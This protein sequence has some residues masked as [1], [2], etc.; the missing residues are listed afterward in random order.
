MANGDKRSVSTDALETLGMIHE[1]EEKR[2]AIHLAVMPVEAGERLNPG[3]HIGIVNGK[4]FVGHPTCIGVVDP[5]LT[6][7][8]GRGERFWL[9]IYPRKIQSL[10]HVWS[11][12]G[13]PD[14][15]P[16]PPDNTEL[17][18]ARR[19]VHEL[20]QDLEVSD[21]ALMSGAKTWLE[22][23]GSYTGYMRFGHDL[24][25]GWDMPKFWNAY[26]LIT[27]ERVPEDKQQAFFSCAC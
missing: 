27:G 3:E 2:D 24:N 20:A 14:E 21:E 23:T 1:R 18:A 10:R 8:V 12:P 17:G 16:A 13:L 6:A 25:Y 9:V 19:V 22:S 26:A 15:L 7:A 5:F 4:A 11:H